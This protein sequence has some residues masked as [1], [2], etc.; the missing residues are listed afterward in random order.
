MVLKMHKDILFYLDGKIPVP[1][2]PIPSYLDIYAKK[3]LKN[4]LFF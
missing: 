2:T 1:Q 4:I 3:W